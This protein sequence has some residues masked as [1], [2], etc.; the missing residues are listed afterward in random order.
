M[1]NWERGRAAPTR[2][3]TAK[4]AGKRFGDYRAGVYMRTLFRDPAA[5]LMH[6]MIYFGFLVLL[7]VTTVLEIDHQLPE[8]LQFLTGQTYQAYAFVADAAGLVFLGG[9]VWAI[10]RRFVQR[11][12]R[13]R[14]KTKPEHALI[15][16][17]F[18]VIGLTGYGAEMFRI[19]LQTAEGEATGY[20]RWSFIGYPLSQLVDGW[21]A[22]SLSTWHQW[23]WIGHVAAFALFL[24]ILPITMLR[25]MFTSPL[26]MY[27][28]DRSGERPKGR[29]EAD[30][31]PRRDGARVVRRLGGRGLHVEATPR[32][33]RLHHVRAV[34]ERVS[35][36]R[37]RQTA[38]PGRSCSRSVR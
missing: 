37:H 15:L 34:H 1:K 3:T 5:G 23:W 12:Y 38:R 26:N 29:D 21:S 30:A 36:P 16:G 17:T 27:L 19:A 10:L 4:N 20:E 24:V 11:P 8:D 32:H 22:S 25:H 14:I 13:I 9:V 28:R 33:G 2:R 18:L 35:G 31:E 6:S 7:G